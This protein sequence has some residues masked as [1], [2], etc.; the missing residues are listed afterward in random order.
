MSVFLDG[1]TRV[2]VQGITGPMGRFQTEEMLRYG[3]KV[4]AGV[5]P[6]KAGEK[7]HDVPVFDTVERAVADTGAEMSILF[8]AA[9]RAKDAIYEAIDASIRRIVCVAEFM[10]VHDVI[11]IKRKLRETATRL[12]GPNCS[13]IISPGKAKVGFY[14]DEVCMPGPVGVM[15]KSGTLSYAALLEMKRRGIGASTVIGVGGDE[16]KGTTF[17]DCVAAFEA[18]PETRAI[19]IIGEIGGRE[20][21]DA[22]AYIADYGTKPVVAL[23]A[24]RTIP[25][26]RS[27]GHAGA[28]I[29]G[30]KG[31]HRSKVEALAGAG[32][33]VAETIEDIPALL[34]ESL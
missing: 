11:E 2:L 17:A 16:V 9:A 13:G 30:G 15:A 6:G 4:V 22:A 21:E 34:R 3:T 18:D 8:V 23:V 7:I 29:V 28:M 32:V 19:L 14:C 5:S 31:T 26:G 10:P 1:G 25:P 33:R 12:I 20:E 24:G 27:V